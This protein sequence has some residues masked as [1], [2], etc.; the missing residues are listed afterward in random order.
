MIQDYINEEVLY[1]TALAMGLDHNDPV[2]RQRLRYK[3]EFLADSGVE[4]ID[5]GDEALQAFMDQH[6]DLYRVEP[7]ISF[8]QIYLGERPDAAEID[9]IRTAAADV[10]TDPGFVQLGA[11]TMLPPRMEFADRR[12]VDRVFGKGSSTRSRTPPTRRGRRRCGR[13]SA[14]TS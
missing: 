14:S 2:I 9:A 3:L 6:S 4:L 5:P 12:E 8:R 13:A 1:R 11:P 10:G 7:R